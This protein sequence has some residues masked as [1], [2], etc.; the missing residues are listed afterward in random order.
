MNPLTL[1]RDVSAAALWW[2]SLP[3]DERRTCYRPHELQAA[4]GIARVN[5]PPVLELL[6]WTRAQRWTRHANRRRLRTY[7]APPGHTVPSVPRGRPSLDV[8]A[9]LAYGP[10]DPYAAFPQ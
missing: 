7:Y 4:T 2:A 5:L 9:L 10:S 6:G 3:P 8:L 1:S